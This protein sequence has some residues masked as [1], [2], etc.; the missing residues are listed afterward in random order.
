LVAALVADAVP[1]ARRG[2]AF[3]IFNMVASLAILAASVIAGGLWDAYGLP[4]TFLAGG[5]V[6]RLALIAFAAVGQQS[7]R[8]PD[9]PHERAST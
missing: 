8:S 2:T 1:A 5:G 9:H 3:G 4:A 6:A 7:R